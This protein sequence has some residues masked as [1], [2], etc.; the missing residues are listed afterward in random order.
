MGKVLV[1][2]SVSLDGFIAD[3]SRPDAGRSTRSPV[4]AWDRSRPRH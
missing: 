2:L 1:G 4:R 3:K